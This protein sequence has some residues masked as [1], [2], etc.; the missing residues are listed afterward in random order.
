[1]QCDCSVNVP[2]LPKLVILN[3]GPLINTCCEFSRKKKEKNTS[4]VA[5]VLR[6]SFCVVFQVYTYNTWQ[7][8]TST[9]DA[10]LVS[11]TFFIAVSRH[12]AFHIPHVAG[13]LRNPARHT[14]SPH[15]CAHNLLRF[16]RRRPSNLSPL[17]C[18]E[19]PQ[20]RASLP[21]NRCAGSQMSGLT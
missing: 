8:V 15:T 20:F 21:K 5:A 10:C 19:T 2:V 11:R 17:S 6:C 1:M 9:S 4:E 18:T 12:S 14:L 3:P 13:E 7:I 16:Q